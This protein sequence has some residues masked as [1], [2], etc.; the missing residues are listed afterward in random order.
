MS[1]VFE[2]FEDDG[3]VI[4]GCPDHSRLILRNV[5]ICQR[6]CSCWRTPALLSTEHSSHNP[7]LHSIYFVEPVLAVLALEYMLLCQHKFQG[8][9]FKEYREDKESP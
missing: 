2:G 8:R 4:S 6:E 9:L 1:F 7:G 3:L 5:G